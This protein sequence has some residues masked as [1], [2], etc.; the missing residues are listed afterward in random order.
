MSLLTSSE[1]KEI[2]SGKD[3][4]GIGGVLSK[5]HGSILWFTLYKTS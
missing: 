3:F 5:K 1:P 2:G 4:L